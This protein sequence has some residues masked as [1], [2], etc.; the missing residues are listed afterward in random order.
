MPDWKQSEARGLI[1]SC[2]ENILHSWQYTM[3]FLGEKGKPPRIESI[4][5]PKQPFGFLGSLLG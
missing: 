3:I 2:L 5:Q 1:L 4:N